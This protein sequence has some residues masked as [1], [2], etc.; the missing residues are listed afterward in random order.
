[1]NAGNELQSYI[2]THHPGDR[3][4]VKIY[5]EGSVTEK[6]VTLKA[7][8]EDKEVVNTSEP[9]KEDEESSVESPGS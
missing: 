9:V 3:V 4:V 2:A 5:R 7:R 6:T 8:E 1:V